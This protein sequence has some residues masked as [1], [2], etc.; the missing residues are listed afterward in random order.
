VQKAQNK[1]AGKI[2][3]I[4]KIATSL[5]GK[6]ALHNGKSK[7][8]TSEYSRQHV[9]KLRAQSDTIITGI[10]TIIADN[11]QMN[12]RLGNGEIIVEPKKIIFDSN[13]RTPVNSNVIKSNAYI[14]HAKNA[15]QCQILNLKSHGANL[16]EVPNSENLINIDKAI[17]EISKIANGQIMLEA[18]GKLFSA[19]L[20]K[21]LINRLYWFRAPIIL[22]DNGINALNGF[23][24]DEIKDA[25]RM[26][27]IDVSKSGE[28][29]LEVY[30]I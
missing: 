4:A 30:E 25:F 16:I 2:N 28:D 1:M 27:L 17:I 18:G 12:V 3:I 19:F 23:N 24:V 9:H 21:K 6:I 8:I 29:I 26:R 5:D 22:G 14:F 20:Q 10:G 11:P 15:P 13:A 7:W